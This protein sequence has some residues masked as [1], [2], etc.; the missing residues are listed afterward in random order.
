MV[1]EF[2]ID[3]VTPE[4]AI[5]LYDKYFEV[6]PDEFTDAIMQYINL[7]PKSGKFLGRVI[8]TIEEKSKV[9]EDAVK[10]QLYIE[11][12]KLKFDEE[13]GDGVIKDDGKL[14]K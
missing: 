8:A 6:N 11:T 13:K 12:G 4:Q 7:D 1:K 5:K 3:G 2:K 14:A 10:E 9:V